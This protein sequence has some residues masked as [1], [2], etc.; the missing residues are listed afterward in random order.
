MWLFILTLAVSFFFA[1]WNGFTDAADAISTVVATRVLKPGQ[2]VLLAASGEFLGVLLGTA[3]AFT[4]G[5]G[6]IDPQIISYKLILAALIGGLIGSGATAIKSWS[7]VNFNGLIHKVVIPMIASPV[8]SFIFAFILIA[9]IMRLFI[10]FST[11]KINPYFRYLQLLSSFSF[12]V[13]HGANDGQK[14]MGILTILLIE[15]GFLQ[16]FKVPLWVMISVNNV[17]ALGTLMGGWRI[18]KTMAKKITHLLPYQG[19][20]AETGSAIVLAVSSVLGFPVSTTHAISGSIMGVGATRGRRSV[21]WSMA[22]KIVFAW[23]LT[24]PVSAVFSMIAYI[25]LDKFI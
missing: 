8:I 6:I 9:I 11:P 15:Q 25:I 7:A 19:F 12:S 10:K 5:Q 20:A 21:S 14:V 22:R 23:I 2:A 16:S 17:I 4:I 18:V 24:I 3:V 13:T 1:F